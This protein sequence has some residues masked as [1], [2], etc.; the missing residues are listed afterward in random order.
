MAP[1][2]QTDRRNALELSVFAQ[3][4]SGDDHLLE[5]VKGKLQEASSLGLVGMGGI[6]KTTLAK[7]LFKTLKR[8]LE[9]A[10]FLENVSNIRDSV[11]DAMLQYTTTGKQF[12]GTGDLVRF[13]TGKRLLLV[14]DDKASDLDVLPTLIDVVHQDSRFIV[15]S[16]DAEL[17][18]LTN[19]LDE[20][21]HVPFL[22]PEDSK[23]LFK[24]YAFG[25][26]ETIP[27]PMQKYAD[28]VVEKCEGLPLSLEVIGKY[29][30]R[31][32]ESI[33]VEA[34]KVLD[35]EKNVAGLNDKLWST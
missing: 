23:E 10:C 15:T 28:M 8:H 29:L 24:T 11:A 25:E 18:C 4:N 32:P 14:I 21:Y 3:A 12:A 22:S 27:P 26:D 35:R 19:V 34:M 5:E 2:E 17:L 16:R 31:Q 1:H 33:W 30:R 7:A 9:C 13:L 6:G 20:I